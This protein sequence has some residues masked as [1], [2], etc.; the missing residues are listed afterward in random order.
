L[1][2]KAKLIWKLHIFGIECWEIIYGHI[3]PVKHN[4]IKAFIVQM[5]LTFF[6]LRKRCF[7]ISAPFTITLTIGWNLVVY[8][9][10]NSDSTAAHPM[11]PHVLGSKF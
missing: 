6:L 5:I 9:H 8:L 3:F 10:L 11:G 1:K 2:Y 7:G 4:Y